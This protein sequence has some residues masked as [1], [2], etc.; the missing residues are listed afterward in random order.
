[1]LYF[2]GSEISNPFSY[3]YTSSASSIVTAPEITFLGTAVN[4]SAGGFSFPSITESDNGRFGPNFQFQVISTSVPEPT[5]TLGFLAL[6]TLGAASTLK[7]KL[8][9]SKSAE[10]ETTK[11]G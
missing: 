10:K 11:V 4:N 8:K 9:P 7:R 6:G 3:L 1:M 2:L 5:S